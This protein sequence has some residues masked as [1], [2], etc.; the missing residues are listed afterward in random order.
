MQIVSEKALLTP[1]SLHE[2]LWR[3]ARA[4]RVSFCS[5]WTISP[6]QAI[7]CGDWD[8][9]HSHM[10]V[11]RRI[12]IRNLL[13]PPKILVR[14]L[15]VLVRRKLEPDF[16]L[17]FL[18]SGQTSFLDLIAHLAPPKSHFFSISLFIFFVAIYCKLKLAC[19][20]V[21]LLPSDFY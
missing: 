2:V 11:L 13:S 21:C 14:I 19:F 10:F 17:P 7:P 12:E 1:I 18:S 15:K 16:I 6:N 3:L 9:F 20:C 5:F 8:S 4:L